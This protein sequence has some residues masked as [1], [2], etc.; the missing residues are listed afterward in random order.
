M[1]SFFTEDEVI[2]RANSSQVG[3]AGYI[4]SSDIDKVYRVANRLQVGMVGIIQDSSATQRYHL[5][6]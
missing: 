3:L 5:G 6:V 4:Y 1:F 2:E